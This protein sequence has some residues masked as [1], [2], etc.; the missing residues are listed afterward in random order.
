METSRGVEGS[1]RM[2]EALGR[3]ALFRGLS[4]TERAQL[5]QGAQV[6][7][8][9]EGK[10]I[11]REGD[12][13]RSLF[14]VLDGLVKMFTH[15]HRGDRILL[16]ALGPDQSFGA[17]G[18]LTGAPRSASVLAAEE[19]LLAELPLA[20]LEETFRQHPEILKT[21]NEL[22]VTRLNVSRDAKA[23]V[24]AQDR[25][26]H[27]RLNI[28]LPVEFEAFPNRGGG[29]TG[30]GQGRLHGTTLDIS[31][32][33]L[34]L[35]MDEP[36]ALDL[37]VGTELSLEVRLAGDAVPLSA[38]GRI[39]SRAPGRAPGCVLYGVMFEEMKTTDTARLKQLIY[40][41]DPT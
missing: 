27:P 23:S 16:A 14:L 18:L 39:R 4:R 11:F 5:A 36:A 6:R 22:S 2:E 13:G 17:T 35:R 41:P 19:S 32:G 26:A 8:W 34:R 3:V 25:R 40:G 24:G 15:D 1:R 33:G 29:G 37:Q 28:Q 20:V 30:R 9:G 21:L 38:W 12:P 7:L 31:L 10:L